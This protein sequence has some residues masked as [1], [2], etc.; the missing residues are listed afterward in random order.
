LFWAALAVGLAWAFRSVFLYGRRRG[1]PATLLA[2][3]GLDVLCGLGNGLLGGA[4]LTAVVRRALLGQGFGGAA[5]FTYDFKFYSVVLLGLLIA[6][7][8]VVCLVQARGLTRGEPQARKRALW[9]SGWLLAISGPLIPLQG[10]AILLSG[11]SLVNLIG[12]AASRKLFH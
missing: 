3:A 12:L 8:G 9:L 1:A 11:L 5:D 10:F 4:H 7:P 2:V 6:V